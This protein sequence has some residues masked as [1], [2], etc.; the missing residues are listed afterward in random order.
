MSETGVSLRDFWKSHFDILD[1]ITLINKARQGVRT[2]TMISAWNK[3]WPGCIAEEFDSYPDEYTH[4]VQTIVDL[5]MSMGLEV[6]G[7]YVEE[8]MRNHRE[9][10]EF[11]TEALQ[12]LHLQLQQTR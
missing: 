3:L 8:L 10:E 6:S 2:R 4:V 12:N 7:E 1:C 9:R 11:T 5:G